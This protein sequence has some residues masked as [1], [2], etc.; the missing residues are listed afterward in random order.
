METVWDQERGLIPKK[1][2]RDAQAGNQP[3]GVIQL[4]DRWRRLGL[5]WAS[6]ATYWSARHCQRWSPGGPSSSAPASWP[7]LGHPCCHSSPPSTLGF[8]SHLFFVIN[9]FFLLQG[10]EATFPPMATVHSSKSGRST[11][12][13]AS[14]VLISAWKEANFKCRNSK[15]RHL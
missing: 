11:S 13:G 6:D 5:L 12:L 8:M 14:E 4:K 9:F 1:A 10:V 15:A 7:C 3:P 2:R